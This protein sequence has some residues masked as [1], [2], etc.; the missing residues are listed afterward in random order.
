MAKGSVLFG[1]T[2]EERAG[3]CFRRLGLERKGAKAQIDCAACAYV[4]RGLM[5][6]R[7]LLQGVPLGG[8]R[9]VAIR[10]A[11]VQVPKSLPCTVEIDMEA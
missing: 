4:P 1:S 9:K 5:H 8:A 3:E 6:R 7:S 11:G 2:L 10:I